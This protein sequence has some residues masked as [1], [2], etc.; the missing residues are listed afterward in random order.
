MSDP[1]DNHD[2]QREPHLRP[3]QF[4]GDPSEKKAAELLAGEGLRSTDSDRVEHTVW[5]EPALSPELAGEPGADQLTY[6]GWLTENIERTTWSH[7]LG[8]T[9]LVALAAGPWGVL[10][11]IAGTRGSSFSILMFTVFGPVAEEVTKVAAALWVVEKKPFLFQ[12]FGQIMICAAC[13]GLAFAAIENLLYIYVYVPD[14]SPEFVEFRWTVCVALHVVCSSIAGLGLVR[15][16]GRTIEQH[17]PPQLSL[18]VPW[19]VVAMIIHGAYNLTV[20]LAS[21]AGWLDLGMPSPSP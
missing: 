13:G 7:S 8:V 15:I 9:L 6:Q 10:A 21:A 12:S 4:I 1:E 5:S 19:F 2:I 3:P 14:H 18:G 20:T 16:W 17:T 11:A